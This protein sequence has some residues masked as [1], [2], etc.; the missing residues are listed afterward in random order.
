MKLATSF[1]LLAL[2]ASADA[3]QLRSS[4]LRT[5]KT[6]TSLRATAVTGYD[7]WT[8]SVLGDLHLDPRYMDDHYAGREHMLKVLEDGTRKNACVVSLGD[9]GESKSVDETKQLYA[10]TSGCLSFAREYLDGYKVPFEVVG[11]NHDLE[12]RR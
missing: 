2:L 9:L 11:G 1:A 7:D 12:G 3:F 10:G 5:P 8:V 6:G 4:I